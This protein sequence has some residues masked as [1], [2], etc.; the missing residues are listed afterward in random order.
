[1]NK[2]FS[3]FPLFL[4]A[5]LFI[6]SG[7]PASATPYYIQNVNPWGTT[8]N[9]TCMNNVFGVGGWI[10]G[11]YSTPAATIFAASTQFVMLEGSDG[12]SAL[13]G[14]M[15]ANQTL[16]ENW[17]NNGGRLFIN[18]A[19]NYG[20]S[21][22]WGFSGTVLNY[23]YYANTVTTTVPT[24]QIFLGPYIPTTTT[25]SGSAFAHAYVS[26]TGLTSILYDIAYAANTHSV[27][28]YKTWGNGIV[29]FGGCTQPNYWTPYSPQGVNLWQNIFSYVNTFPLVGITT[30]VTGSP[31]CAGASITVNYSSFNLA[32][33]AGNQ[34]K[35]QL[36]DASGSFAV[37][38]QI[39]VIT[40]TA[41]S[42]AIT[43]TIPVA[44]P[45]GTA[46]R[47]RTVS[48][49]APF[50]GADNGTNLTINPLLTPSVTITANPAGP[51]CAGTNVTFTATVTNGGPSPTYQ[52]KINN[53]AVPLATNPTFSTST[54]NNN[55]AVTCTI[56]SNATCASPTTAT[57][58]IITMTVNPNLTPTIVITANP[59]NVLCIGQSVTFTATITNG[60]PSPTY[61][62]KLNGNPVG[63]NQP[64]YTTNSLNN[65][66]VITCVLTSN[67]TCLTTATVTSAPITITVNPNIL[68]TVTIT[69]NPGNPA[70]SGS[71]VT[72][73]ANITNGG[74]TP[75]YAWKV[76]GNPVG[77]NSP[78]YSNNA[79]ANGAV[80]TCTVTSNAT[81]ANPA[82]VTGTMVMTI[83][84]TVTPTINI[85]ANPGTTICAGTAVTFTAN[86]TNGGPVPS[87]QWYDNGN[88]V[89]VNSPTFTSS[90][91]A[92]GDVIT[93]TMTSN[94]AC[95]SPLAVTS[96]GLVMTVNPVL[97]PTVSVST[98]PG[99][100][101]CNGTNVTFS[102]GTTNGGPNPQYQWYVNGNPVSNTSTF[103]S[104]TLANGDAVTCELTSN[105]TCAAPATVTSSTVTMIVYLSVTPAVTVT[106][107]TGNTICAGTNVTFTATP[108]N[109][110]PTPLYQWYR[111]GNPVGNSSA[112]YMDNTLANN[113]VISCNMTSNAAC[114]NPLLVSS[115]SIGMT[116]IP[117]VTPIVSVSASPGSN[118]CAGTNVTFNASVTNGGPAPVYQWKKNG[119]NVGGNSPTYANNALNNTDVISCTVTSNATCATPATVNSNNI[120]MG[121]TSAVVPGISI[122]AAPGNV[123]CLNTPVTFTATASNGGP[124]PTYQWYVNGNPAGPNATSFTSATLA[125]N[126]VV[127]CGLTSNAACA[128]PP[129]VGSNGITM[130]VTGVVA[131]GISITAST[132]DTICQGAVVTFTANAVNGG[133]NPIY[134][135]MKNGNP[136]GTP[137]ATY[138]DNGLFNND[139]ISCVLISSDPCPSPLTDTSNSKQ[140]IVNQ[141]LSPSVYLSGTPNICTGNTLSL[142]ALAYNAGP[143]PAYQWMLNGVPDGN[144]PT[145]TAN[146]LNDGDV[147]YCKLTTNAP[148]VTQNATN[149]DIDT[150]RWFNSNYLAGTMGGT[151]TNTVNVADSNKKI[152]G[153]NDCDLICTVIPAGNNAVSGNVDAGVTLDATVNNFKGQPYLQRHY[154]IMPANDPLS[155]TATIKL[156][157]YQYEFDAFDSLLVHSGLNYPPLPSNH[158]DN[159]FIRITEF[160]GTGT[161]PGNYT[162]NEEFIVPSVMYD[163]AANWWVMTFDVK[164][165]GG[166]YIHTTTAISPLAVSGV[167]GDA[168]TIE[169]YP[170]PVLDKVE[171]R[172]KGKHDK[173]GHLIVTD[174]AGRTLINVPM[175]NEKAL[176]DM[177]SLASGIYMLRYHDD[178][179]TETLK[180]TKQ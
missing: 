147:V 35:V 153:Y 91:L 57:S 135:W 100:M 73:T 60:G 25:Y 80:V 103:S 84:P 141:Y 134:N 16:I 50:T 83:Y 97:V 86:T 127:S 68:P 136:V 160:H 159:G 62:W 156:Y 139:I 45:G 23:A 172:V 132:S 116:V 122:T 113:D 178:L 7:R 174:L 94:A 67:A 177:S 63:N 167:S 117:T 87:F 54:L 72:F 140:M 51:I 43:C 137:S 161:A 1:M 74:P 165:F 118:I 169:A 128:T 108:A 133:P 49:S 4:L 65:A 2:L 28:C 70:C 19:P 179:V 150:V 107:N 34:F 176:V 101:I 170:N 155:A 3:C 110:G 76:N 38:T 29:F 10:Q 138:T 171:V 71:N 102:A 66:D 14:F 95:P 82:T 124:T 105:A 31:W 104:T 52:W 120:T 41:A 131:P 129:T 33:S 144:G 175:E 37:P 148:C 36:S 32:F 96:A 69:A 145:W 15:T 180:I 78:T 166:F 6:L 22:N 142:S 58:N 8:Q 40:S 20:S 163:T 115:N 27:L 157:A 55:D 30:T 92:N 47:I 119:N 13:P 89:G 121:V 106:N 152:I 173:G 46:Y 39:G 61:A 143:T 85:T 26:G 99:N 53:V 149:S 162:G 9:I 48:T 146:M 12:N 79:L 112:T 90:G 11:T 151:E 126:D 111:N 5:A 81:C 168:F 75:V 42:G 154:D 114:A 109:G 18:A 130:V 56:T 24:N 64:T 17:V 59:G 123:I 158:T 21:Q 93:C 164:G 77:G 44:Q 125:A 98:S 88:P